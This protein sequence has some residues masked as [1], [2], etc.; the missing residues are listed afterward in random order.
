[1]CIV[2]SGAFDLLPRTARVIQTC[3]AAARQREVWDREQSMHDTHIIR[4]P[5]GLLTPY[6]LPHMQ[7]VPLSWP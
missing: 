6:V 3:T 2:T 5:A 1:M 7:H 4:P